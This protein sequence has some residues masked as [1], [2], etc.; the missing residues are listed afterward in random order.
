MTYYK[1][2]SF[3][4]GILLGNGPILNS[5]IMRSQVV[6]ETN[7]HLLHHFGGM[8]AWKSGLRFWI[9]ALNVPFLGTLKWA[10]FPK[11]VIF[12]HVAK[13]RQGSPRVAK[14]QGGPQGWV[15][16]VKTRSI[17][18]ESFSAMIFKIKNCPIEIPI[19]NEKWPLDLSYG[20]IILKIVL[21]LIL[22]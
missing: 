15:R 10:L 16:W 18:F 9:R 12:K 20:S 22:P 21:W 8:L 14:V 7:K 6:N 13:G 3:S 19:K 11:M 2:F 1:P 5:L 17:I 4:M